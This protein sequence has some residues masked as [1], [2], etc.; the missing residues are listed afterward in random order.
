ML[1]FPPAF[2]AGDIVDSGD[3]FQLANHVFNTLQEHSYNYKEKCAQQLHEK[4]ECFIHE[5][6][7]S[8][9]QDTSDA[10]QDG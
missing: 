3:D 8:R 9:C 7:S 2:P 10:I 1:Q 4:K 6:A 5:L